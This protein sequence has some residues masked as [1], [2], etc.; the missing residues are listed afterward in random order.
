MY[1]TWIPTRVQARTHFHVAIQSREN[2]HEARDVRY[3]S[4]AIRVAQQPQRLGSSGTELRFRET[5]DDERDGGDARFGL[6]GEPGRV[7]ADELESC[8]SQREEAAGR[9]ASDDCWA[10]QAGQE[11]TLV[12][13]YSF[14]DRRQDEERSLEVLECTF[15]MVSH[16]EELR[17]SSPSEGPSAGLAICCSARLT[18][19]ASIDSRKM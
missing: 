7:G 16:H 13:W 8:C 6:R 10:E 14:L 2:L 3:Q 5:C 18:I 11:G 12:G 1:Q 4:L 15:S 19:P 9:E 17:T